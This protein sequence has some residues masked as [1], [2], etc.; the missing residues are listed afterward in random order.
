MG[1]YLYAILP[2]GLVP[3]A[4]LTGVGNRAVD[5]LDTDELTLWV[6]A[7]ERAPAAS[8]DGIRSHNRVVEEA[9]RAATP[10][11]VR[12]GQ[13]VESP[14]ALLRS[15]AE[16]T[17]A[18]RAALEKVRDAVEFGVRV[19]DPE[20]A[21]GD[22]AGTTRDRTSGTAYLQS[23]A[24]S[25]LDRARLAPRARAVADSLTAAL[26]DLVRAHREEPLPSSH[27]LF[28]AAHL[29]ARHEISRYRTALDSFRA[30]T[31]DLHFLVSGPWPPYSFVG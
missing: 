7:M 1:V 4:G 23:L 8:I 18:Y 6:S 29:V 2:A 11:P 20:R 21:Q 27:G 16:K 25:Q 3:P 24:R 19:I 12:F 28:S 17:D 15:I 9:M 5:S 30:R 31:E 26:G 10:V 14:A 22:A 13:W